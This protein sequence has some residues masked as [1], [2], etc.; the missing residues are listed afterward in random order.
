MY[1]Y[2]TLYYQYIIIPLSRDKWIV[3]KTGFFNEFMTK[4]DSFYIT[5]VSFI[6][7]AVWLPK[8]KIFIYFFGLLLARVG[9]SSTSPLFASY[10][11]TR[12]GWA[13]LSKS[14]FF[15]LSP[16]SVLFLQD[17]YRL[18]FLQPRYKVI[19]CHGIHTAV[20]AIRIRN[21]EEHLLSLT[22]HICCFCTPSLPFFMDGI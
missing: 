21:P 3:M 8:K 19:I 6:Q 22:N 1:H 15:R 20:I 2:I 16:D 18:S 9:P 11:A 12:H 13:L 10:F 5:G 17:Q 14:L 4:N 7:E